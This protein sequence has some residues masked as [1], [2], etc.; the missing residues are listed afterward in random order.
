[1]SLIKCPECGR[2]V[3][4]TIYR[5]QNCGFTIRKP[6]RGITGTIFKFIFIGF[7]AIMIFMIVNMLI[8]STQTTDIATPSGGGMAIG[9]LIFI[10]IFAG[11]PLALMNYLTRPK[12]FE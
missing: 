11:I 12:A 4:D 3:S 7:N 10:W 1:M 5:C 2:E 8:V 6:K 9:M